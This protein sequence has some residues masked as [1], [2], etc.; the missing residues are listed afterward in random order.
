MLGGK[1]AQEVVFLLQILFLSFFIEMLVTSEVSTN[2]GHRQGCSMSPLYLTLPVCTH[3]VTEY[4]GLNGKFLCFRR[5][6]VSI[7][8][9]VIC[10][11][12]FDVCLAITY[13]MQAMEII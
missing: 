6:G 3:K 10:L 9:T 13:I 1:G 11:S 12:N 2:T 5:D 4:I 7:S 8:Y